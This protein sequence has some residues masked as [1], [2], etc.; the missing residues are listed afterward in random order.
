MT[1]IGY[2]PGTVRILLYSRR[3]QSEWLGRYIA[4]P[5]F[6]TVYIY[7][8]ECSVGPINFALEIGVKAISPMRV[9]VGGAFDKRRLANQCDKAAIAVALKY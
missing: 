1:L 9:D 8:N 2:L 7:I 6:H 3:M 5:E 4:N